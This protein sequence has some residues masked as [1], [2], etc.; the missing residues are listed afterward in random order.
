MRYA[1]AYVHLLRCAL[2]RGLSKVIR[3]LPYMCLKVRINYININIRVWKEGRETSF[4]LVALEVGED[5]AGAI[6]T[7]SLVGK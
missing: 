5:S 3:V 1:R 6:T 7:R 4:K 2:V